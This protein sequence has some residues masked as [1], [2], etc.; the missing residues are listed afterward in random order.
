MEHHYKKFRVPG[1]FESQDSVLLMWPRSPYITADHQL[2]RDRVAVEIVAAL[3]GRVRIFVSCYNEALVD[4]ARNKLIK[5]GFQTNQ[6]EFLTYPCPIIYP[7]DFGAQVMVGPQGER[8][9]VDFANTEYGSSPYGSP[10]ARSM[11]AFGQFHAR[12]L[13]ITQTRFSRLVSE[14]GDR[15][16][17]GQGIMMCLEHTEVSHRNPGWTKEEVEQEFKGL[18]ELDQV[19]WIPRGTYDDED[20]YSGPIPDEQ[21]RYTAYRS[22]SANGHIDEFCRFVGPQTILLAEITEQEARTS[23]LHRLNKER[24]DVAYEVLRN[25]R[26]IDGHRFTIIRIPFPEPIF[27]RLTPED[28][29][30]SIFSSGAREHG[31]F[32]FDGSP[33]PTGPIR[34]LPALSY[35]NFLVTN[36]AVVCQKYHRPE[37]FPACVVMDNLDEANE[38]MKIKD[39]QAQDVLQKAFPGRQIIAIDTLALNMHGGGIHCNTRNVP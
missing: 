35:A 16:F 20:V 27:V 4:H 33:F 9:H 21:N 7:R 22:A 13:G 24:L 6:I 23:E 3:E 11:E 34:V 25:A 28:N 30:Y 12:A 19:V 8:L 14:G 29:L 39:Q 36:D 18:F 2:D 15:E 10:L 17:N 31:G 5:H 1:E 38:K 37:G 26:T 32:M